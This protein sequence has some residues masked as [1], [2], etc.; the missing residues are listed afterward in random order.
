[1][2]KIRVDG[3]C[4]IVSFILLFIL[5]VNSCDSMYSLRKIAKQE[6]KQTEAVGSTMKE[7]N[8][9]C[10]KFLQIKGVAK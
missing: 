10:G 7:I 5:T 1:M 3:G 4:G 2:E 9:A 6:E 8:E